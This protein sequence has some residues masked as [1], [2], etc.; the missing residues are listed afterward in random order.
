VPEPV[1]EAATTATPDA[2]IAVYADGPHNAEAL[3]V[4]GDEL[5]IVTKDLTAGLY[6][7]TRPFPGSGDLTFERIGQLDMPMVTDAEASPDGSWVV[8]RTPHVAAIYDTADLLR[9]GTVRPRT[10]IDLDGLREPQGE[11][12]A[13]GDDG[14]LYLTS[15][16][17]SWNRAGRLTS[18]RCLWH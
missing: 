10:R 9:G 3:F 5:F 13:L 7:S 4:V 15:E 18:L 16:G 8:V 17:R 2:F 14:A 6:R 1:P 11:G 12:A